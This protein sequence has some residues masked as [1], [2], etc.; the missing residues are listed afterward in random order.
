[1]SDEQL[2]K[3][4]FKQMSLKKKIGHIWEYYR[5]HFFIAVFLIVSAVSIINAVFIHPAP[6][7]YVG[8]SFYGIHAADDFS[9]E[10]ANYL[11]DTVVPKEENKEV[12]V[13]AFYDYDGD[14]TVKVD[15]WQRFETLLMAKELDILIADE[16]EFK[17]LVY[18][19]Y[20]V[21]LDAFLDEKYISSFDDEMIFEGN[22]IQ[23]S[24]IR[25]YGICVKNSKLLKNQYV[26]FSKTYIGIVRQS[27]NGDNTVKTVKEILKD[28]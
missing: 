21:E 5:L 9:Q 4:Q 22:N 15:L 20:I 10:V 14:S 17:E 7:L 2:A 25:K 6:K 13:S 26:D 8:I 1:M 19:G 18:Q 3:E 28:G 27:I 16:E 23:D 12:R 11:T 24:Q